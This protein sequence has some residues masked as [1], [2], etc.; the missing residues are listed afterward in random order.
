MQLVQVPSKPA[1]GTRFRQAEV[2]RIENRTGQ[3][4]PRGSIE[5]AQ[6]EKCVLAGRRA[7]LLQ[8]L[9]RS[10]AQR[11]ITTAQRVEER[12][13]RRPGVAACEA[14]YVLGDETPLSIQ[15]AA[16]IPIKHRAACV[17]SAPYD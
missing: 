10:A 17:V 3:E 15:S 13:S 16:G 12:R 8:P 9:D 5:P 11:M 2:S 14:A 7:T 4:V 1:I 6:H